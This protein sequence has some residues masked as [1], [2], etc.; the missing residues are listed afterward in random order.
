VA[1][2]H[3]DVLGIASEHDDEAG[4]KRGANTSLTFTL[5]G[6]RVAHFG[7]FGQ[8]ALR[9]VQAA[10]LGTVDL[11][12]VPVGGGLTIG[13]GQ[14]AEIAGRLQARWIVPMHN[15]TERISR[16]EPLDDFASRFAHVARLDAP[17]FDLDELPG[18]RPLVVVPSA[19]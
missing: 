14:A 2:T 6:V 19:P 16:L 5:D 18:E 11:L 9:D 1:G 7:D 12:F 15:R 3:G 17:R 8:A 13:T 4:T 10:V